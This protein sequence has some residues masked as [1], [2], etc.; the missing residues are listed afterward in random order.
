MAL[1]VDEHRDRRPAQR[2]IRQPRRKR[3]RVIVDSLHQR[4]PRT[5]DRHR[6]DVV[7]ALHRQMASRALAVKVAIGAIRFQVQPAP[8]APSPSIRRRILLRVFDHQL[9]LDKL[10]RIHQTVATELLLPRNL[11]KACSVRPWR[12]VASLRR[13]NGN[14]IAQDETKRIVIASIRE[15]ERLP[16][17]KTRIERNTVP[18]R[19]YVAQ[20]RQKRSGRGSTCT[21]RS[22]RCRQL[23][24]R[25]QIRF[26]RCQLFC[27]NLRVRMKRKKPR[28]RHRAKLNHIDGFIQRRLLRSRRLASDGREIQVLARCKNVLSNQPVRRLDLIEPRKPPLVGMTAV[29]ILLEDLVDIRRHLDLRRRRLGRYA[30]PHELQKNKHNNSRNRELRQAPHRSLLS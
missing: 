11:R 21:L 9:H 15:A 23:G 7:I 19:L 16:R 13:F 3:G 24:P 14:V 22:N 18:F 17:F 26:Q 5:R 12:N 4:R 25:S 28:Q 8:S 29:A 10:S 27:R 20:R 6:V 30:R 2:L 1:P